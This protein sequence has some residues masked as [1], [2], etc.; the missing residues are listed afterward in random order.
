MFYYSQEGSVNQNLLHI[1]EA[2]TSEETVCYRSLGSPRGHLGQTRETSDKGQ[3]VNNSFRAIYFQYI[4]F[5]VWIQ[6]CW[7]KSRKD[8][9]ILLADVDFNVTIISTN[10]S[11]CYLVLSNFNKIR[12]KNKR[13]QNNF[14]SNIIVFSFPWCFWLSGFSLVCLFWIK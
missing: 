5:N 2:R 6:Y 4:I 11:P 7:V 10:I 14:W 12:E 13:K 9:E 3:I 1:Q 8:T